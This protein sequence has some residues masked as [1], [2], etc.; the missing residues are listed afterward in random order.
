MG[1]SY[2]ADSQG[3]LSCD[4]LLSVRA[5]SIQHLY[6]NNRHRFYLTQN[7]GPVLQ[8]AHDV[9]LFTTATQIM[10]LIPP[11][12]R[13]P[14]QSGMRLKG[15][16]REISVL[17]NK[18]VSF[19]NLVEQPVY[20]MQV[21]NQKHLICTQIFSLLQRIVRHSVVSN[22]CKI[23]DF[24]PI[25]VQCTVQNKTSAC[26]HG[27]LQVFLGSSQFTTEHCQKS[28]ANERHS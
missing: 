21:V 11:A 9:S 16:S 25:P 28:V 3:L 20:F 23:S 10:F 27:A 5:V 24:Q 6:S 14:S 26:R 1:V 22:R 12:S 8:G 17:A 4:E 15:H 2:W 18:N 7:A 19:S 13:L